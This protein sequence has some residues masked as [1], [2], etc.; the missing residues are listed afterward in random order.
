MPQVKDDIG[1][2]ILFDAPASRI[3]SLYSGHT[4]NLIAIGAGNLLVAVGQGDDDIGLDFLPRLGVRP[5]VEQIAALKP[6]LVLSR[7]MQVRGQPA[8]YDRLRSLGVNI[9]A[10]DPPAWDEFP[11]YI[12]LLAALTGMGAESGFAASEAMRASKL[13]PLSGDKALGVFLVTVGRTIS[14]CTPDSWAA[15]ILE[16]AGFR[17]VA[18]D[19]APLSLGSVIAAFGAER[20]LASDN[21]VDVILLQQGAMNATKAADFMKDAR[22]SGLRAVRNGKVFDVSEADISRPSLLRLR[23]GI[24]KS[25]QRLVAVGGDSDG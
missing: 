22:F 10:L 2:K 16:S 7:P 1:G 25:L 6:D 17:N 14:T 13:A 15:H 18:T 5:G 4:E 24:V 19:V 12:D 9:V 21:E 23:R 20:L 3:I 11:A 8:L